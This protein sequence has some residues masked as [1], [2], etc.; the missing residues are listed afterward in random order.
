M[1]DATLSESRNPEGTTILK[2]SR[3]LIGALFAIL[4]LQLGFL[5]TR[6]VADKIGQSNWIERAGVAATSLQVHPVLGGAPSTLRDAVVGT[7]HCTLV[8]GV[9]PACGVCR[10]MRGTWRR[11]FVAWERNVALP[12]SAMWLSVSDSASASAFYRHA[13]LAGIA[14]M[15]SV[16]SPREVATKLALVATPTTYVF[17]RA[18]T[19]QGRVIGDVLPRLDST[20]AWCK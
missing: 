3:W 18:G 14:Q 8:V 1:A 12:L 4:V 9:D 11:S 17:S 6:F 19:L 10:E 20:Q 5:G 16:G 2:R 13:D 7:G 15:V